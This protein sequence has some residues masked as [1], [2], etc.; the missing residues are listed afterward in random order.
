MIEKF[1]AAGLSTAE[2]DEAIKTRTTA[3]NKACREHKKKIIEKRKQDGQK[4]RR[5]SLKNNKQ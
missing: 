4:G 1:N 2:A 3:F 5:N